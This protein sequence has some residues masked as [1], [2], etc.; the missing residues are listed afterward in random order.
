[1]KHALLK[2]LAVGL[3]ATAVATAA[4]Q[5]ISDDMVRIGVLSDMSGLYSDT[6][7][8][9]SVEAAKMAVEDFGGTVLGKK[10]EVV[11]A[12]HQN[13]T[14]VGA[15][16]ARTWFDRDG[17][18]LIIDMN[19]SAVAAAINNLARERNRLVIN[20]GGA[21][22]GLTN[23]HCAPT[24]IHYTYDTYALANGAV[25]GILEQ[26]KKN[27]FI[28]AVD[29]GFGK[30][31]AA[32]VSEFL[33]DG[34]GKVVGSTYHPLS[35]TDFGAFLLQAQASGADVVNLANG[36]LDT[37][38]SIRA[39]N[40]F[41]ITAT[42]TV[43]PN[44]LF[45]NDV[46]AL[47]LK[48]GQ[49]MVLA[50]GFYWDRTEDTRA[51]SKRFYERMDKMPSMIHA[52]AY[53][54]VTQY[55]KAIQATETDDGKT[56]TAYLKENPIEDF[57]AENGRVREDGRMVHDMYLVQLKKPEESKYPW[58]YY[59]VL[60]TIPGDEAFRPLSKGTCKFVNGKS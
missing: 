1:M 10:V 25:R 34:G 37:V 33:A 57:F 7:G 21:S 42:Q 44:L 31:M 23:D 38:N 49:G 22:N 32:D 58:D 6:A 35:T 19:N 59:H 51:W 26:G 5:G 16:Q 47:G 4:A 53:S 15:T 14:D 50:T 41:G 36:T 52:G 39:A 29:Y 43:V 28:L 30:A 18:D 9:G 11:F 24:A 13:K 55:L 46:H 3:G 20:T 60:A 48:Y 27:W 8:M 40:E 17:V 56:V 12:D 2:S 54:A 45:I